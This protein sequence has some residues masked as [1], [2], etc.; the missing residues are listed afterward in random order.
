MGI[1]LVVMHWRG[2]I[3]LEGDAAP[4][5]KSLYTCKYRGS[6][7]ALSRE[8]PLGARVH[9]KVAIK[10]QKHILCAIKVVFKTS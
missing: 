10:S 7:M 5:K 8:E 4:K 3:L 1:L 9:L 2:N 6:F